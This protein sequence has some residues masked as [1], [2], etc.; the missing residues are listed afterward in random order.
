MLLQMCVGLVAVLVSE[1]VLC[2]MEQ[3]VMF[4]KAMPDAMPDSCW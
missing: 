4:D 3:K 1:G 2:H